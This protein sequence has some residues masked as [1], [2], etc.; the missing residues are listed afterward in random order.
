MK[1]KE[2]EL[3]NIKS[4][5]GHITCAFDDL[6]SIFSISGKNGAGKS[7][8][9]KSAY[10]IQKAYFS[11]LLG[12][13]HWIEFEHEVK[14]FLNSYDSIIRLVLCDKDEDCILT[15]KYTNK[16]IDL[17]YSN[18]KFIKKYWNLTSPENLILYIDASKGFS[19]DTLKFNELNISDNSRNDLA[20]E[21]VL[22]PGL[23]FSGIYR[24]LVK[25]HIH[26]R[27]IPSKPDRLLYFRVASKMFTS[28]IPNVE[29]RN[30]SGKHKPGEF[31]LLG[32]ANTDKRKPLY[33]VREFSSGEKALLSTLAFLCISKSVC[34][35]FI[36]EPENH[37]HESLLLE[38]VSLLHA[39]CESGGLLGWATKENEAEG[40]IN[41][42]EEWLEKE[43]KDHRL[44]QV[45]LSTHSKTL[46][47]K[48]FTVGKNFTVSSSI[49]E[50]N[51]DDAENELRGLGLSSI[52]SKVLLVEGTGD[53]ESLEYILKGK[54]V[55]I[56]PLGGSK[57]VI[58]T[59]KKLVV[60][61]KHIRE[62]EFVFLVDSDNKPEEYFEKIRALDEDFYDKTFIK[63]SKHEFENYLLDADIFEHV[64]NQYIEIS[65]ESDKKITK[66]EINQQ[67]SELAKKSLPQ[68]YK[69]ETS[70]VLNHKIDSYFSRKIWGNK[71]FV[72]DSKEKI[73]EQIINQALDET[74]IQALANDLKESVTSVFDAYTQN[75]DTTL[76]DRCDGKQVFGLASAF[77]SKYT[78]I[79]N[80]VFKKAIYRKAER[81]EGSQLTGLIREILN[82]F[83]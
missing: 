35:L 83:S 63:L 14:R 60:L 51:Y 33:D 79:D 5:D 20:I 25:D 80:K 38:F 11:K 2:I 44:N 52:Y 8:I 3:N 76:I 72:W 34:A 62:M 78:G 4:F 74:S 73:L 6:T 27:L 36:D 69:K 64:I 54:S 23:L 37:F 32:K 77:F 55:T 16:T 70:L 42:K 43:Y 67:F 29:L 58:E 28:L 12:D 21:A 61:R 45:V 66:E 57:E 50:L 22:R 59:F 82:R 71:D 24:Q 30:F 53:H 7:T 47:Y 26:G 46:I 40:Q 39:L 18:E 15:L 41:L 9:L 81:T 49:K 17:E 68:V 56:K 10:L 13:S 75:A 19:E 1:I 31:V 65:G 48:I